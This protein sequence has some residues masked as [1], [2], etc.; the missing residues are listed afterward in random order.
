MTC[1]ILKDFIR[2]DFLQMSL[3]V[4]INTEVNIIKIMTEKLYINY[5]R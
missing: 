3:R 5:N 2:T 1:D 4:I